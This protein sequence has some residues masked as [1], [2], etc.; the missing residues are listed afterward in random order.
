MSSSWKPTTRNDH[1]DRLEEL[2]EEMGFT[3][4]TSN[5]EAA[6][7]ADVLLL[8]VKPKGAR[9]VL[10][11]LGQAGALDHSPLVVSIAAGVSTQALEEAAGKSIRVVRAMPNTPALVQAGALSEHDDTA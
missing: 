4:G 2:T 10:E 9:M 5:A 6:S 1:A 11:E 8:C 7:E 3:V